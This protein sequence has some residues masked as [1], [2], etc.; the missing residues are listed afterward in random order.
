[1]R[2]PLAM[3]ANSAAS[4]GV[5]TIAGEAPAARSTLAMKLAETVLVI[6]CTSGF[7][8][9]S[10]VCAATTSSTVGAR[11]A[12]SESGMGDLGWTSKDDML[13][14]ISLLYFGDPRKE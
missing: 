5:S 11:A 14:I 1:M 4:S 2:R 7:C 12:D 3:P 6:A 13:Y 8:A 10:A 9:R